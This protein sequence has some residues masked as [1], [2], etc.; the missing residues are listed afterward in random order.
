VPGLNDIATAGVDQLGHPVIYYNPAEM[1]QSGV[2][3]PY[4]FIAHEYGHHRLG[5]IIMKYIDANNPYV[6]NWLTLN[7]ENQADAFAVDYWIQRGDKRPIQ[8]GY[9]AFL[10]WDN[11]GD[12]THPPSAVR[13]QNVA[14]RFVQRTN[15][16]LFP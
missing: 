10:A 7:A 4:F 3:A 15:T 13:A 2:F 1:N 9:N 14:Q 12:Q 16:S 11:P 5:H 6:Q 8:A